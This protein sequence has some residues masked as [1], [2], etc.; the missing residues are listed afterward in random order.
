M[1]IISLNPTECSSSPTVAAT[2]FI[3]LSSISFLISSSV[4]TS[5]LGGITKSS[6][7]IVNPTTPFNSI[8]VPSA[9]CIISL[10][11]TSTSSKPNLLPISKAANSATL[12]SAGKNIVIKTTPSP[13]HCTSGFSLDVFLSS[14]VSSNLR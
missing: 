2:I 13:S 14:F 3:G 9:S 6:I 12:S 1:S 7:S 5:G 10:W 11:I 8:L 4:K